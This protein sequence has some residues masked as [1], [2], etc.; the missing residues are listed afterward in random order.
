MAYL[1]GRV[2]R[3]SAQIASNYTSG[4][5]NG[6]EMEVQVAEQWHEAK[7]VRKTFT[8]AEVTYVKGN[9]GG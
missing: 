5:E 2:F 3:R 1:L 4:T 8:F 9:T 7:A 6:D